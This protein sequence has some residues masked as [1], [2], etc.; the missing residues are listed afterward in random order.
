MAAP[1]WFSPFRDLDPIL[2]RFNAHTVKA[3]ILRGKLKKE[4]RTGHGHHS[5][6]WERLATALLIRLEG[7]LLNAELLR[8]E[9]CLQLAAHCVKC[10]ISVERSLWA[11][12]DVWSC[13]Q[14]WRPDIPQRIVTCPWCGS[15]IWRYRSANEFCSLCGLAPQV[16]KGH[17]E[18]VTKTLSQLTAYIRDKRRLSEQTFGDFDPQVRAYYN[19][20]RRLLL[21]PVCRRLETTSSLPAHVEDPEAFLAVWQFVFE[22]ASP[23][24][25]H[26]FQ[27]SV[28]GRV[29]VDPRRKHCS[30]TCHIKASRQPAADRR[31]QAGMTTG[32]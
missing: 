15:L 9:I 20:V 22:G 32:S 4:L 21:M 28:C 25:R 3:A 12:Y 14:A 7:R 13:L 17:E 2:R 24:V 19:S 18:T 11:W 16:L 23:T 6:H 5:L 30:R 29:V 31:R 27:C 26:A 8:F 10:G 1:R